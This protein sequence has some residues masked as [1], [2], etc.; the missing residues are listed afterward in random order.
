[1]NP[2]FLLFIAIILTLVGCEN[3]KNVFEESDLN[4]MKKE[5]LD[6]IL[7]AEMEEGPFSLDY[8][9]KTVC[10]SKNLISLLGE[11]NVYDCMPHGWKRYEGKT[12]VKI[13]EKFK[14]ITLNDL[15]VSKEQTEKRSCLALRTRLS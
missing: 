15:F 8:S 13:H 14:E 3:K 1:M 5:F 2:Q 7:L 9:M 4:S 11:I 6:K 10:Y 12:Y